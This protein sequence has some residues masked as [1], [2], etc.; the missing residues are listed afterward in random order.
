MSRMIFEGR[1]TKIDDVADHTYMHPA[2]GDDFKCWGS[3]TGPD[4]RLIISGQGLYD[5]ANCYRDPVTIAGKTYPDTAGIGL[6]AINGVCHQSCNCFLYSAGV[7]LTLNVR[8]YWASVSIYGFYGNISPAGGPVGAAIHFA[9]WLAA[10]Y[11]PC[12]QKFK[13]SVVAEEAVTA[14]PGKGDTLF[15]A[16]Q[17]LYED[18]GEKKM[19]PSELVI[20]EAAA[21]AVHTIPDFDPIKYEDLHT[22]FLKEVNTVIKSGLKGERLADKINDL[23]VQFQKAMAERLDPNDYE[24]L[25]GMPAGE[26]I[27]IIDPEIA[28]AAAKGK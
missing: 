27:N 28:K 9:W 25:F 1:A 5:V 3:N 16:I 23:S 18:V 26:T 10:V 6:Y 14:N 7:L 19:S 4:N 21:L 13:P 12:Y 20:K 2:S 8:G 24:K 22:D 11:N 15:S 17:Q